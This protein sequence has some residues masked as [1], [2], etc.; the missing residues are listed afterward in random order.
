MDS[1]TGRLRRCLYIMSPK[2]RPRMLTPMPAISHVR[3]LMPIGDTRPRSGSFNSASPWASNGA[4]PERASRT[5]KTSGQT[6]LET[7][8]NEVENI[9]EHPPVLLE[10]E[11]ETI[12]WVEESLLATIPHPAQVAQQNRKFL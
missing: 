12:P 5:S 1:C 7:A 11:I 3:P 10:R 8:D 6:R 4:D 9:Q 2:T